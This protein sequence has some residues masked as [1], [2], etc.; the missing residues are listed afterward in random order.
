MSWWNWGLGGNWPHVPP[1]C[2]ACAH[3]HGRWITITGISGRHFSN[4]SRDSCIVPACGVALRNHPPI[5]RLIGNPSLFVRPSVLL[6]PSFRHSL[7]FLSYRI[8][9]LFRYDNA[10]RRHP[11]P[12][13]CRFPCV[14]LILLSSAG[15][16]APP[17]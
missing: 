12:L 3:L 15:R 6:C 1:S 10:F 17:L 13:P 7:V 5:P 2:A 4:S 14:K 9:N 8:P 16:E 11:M